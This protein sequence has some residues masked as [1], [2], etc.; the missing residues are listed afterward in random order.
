MVK[1]NESV[2]DQ[3]DV[4]ALS[5]LVCGADVVYKARRRAISAA[6]TECH[7]V[8]NR[9]FPRVVFWGFT[10]RDRSFSWWKKSLNHLFHFIEHLIVTV[11]ELGRFGPCPFDKVDAILIPYLV[12]RAQWQ[13]KFHFHNEVLLKRIFPNAQVV[14]GVTGARHFLRKYQAQWHAS[15][16]E[17]QAKE[18]SKPDDTIN[19]PMCGKEQTYLSLTSFSPPLGDGVA[20]NVAGSSL[21]GNGG[22]H[23]MM[24]KYALTSAR[25][26]PARLWHSMLFGDAHLFS[27]HSRLRV[28]YIDRQ[29]GPTL[30]RRLPT[31]WH[32]AIV[33]YLSQAKNV[34]F[35]HLKM[36]DYKFEKQMEMA[37]NID[38][39]V[40]AHGNGLSHQMFM[41]PH[42]FVLEIFGKFEFQYDY[43]FLSIC[44]GHKYYCLY[45]D[46]G[47]VD[48]SR[49]LV[50]RRTLPANLRR[51]NVTNSEEKAAEVAQVV[52]SIVEYA[53]Q[54]LIT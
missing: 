41:R 54:I 35:L 16:Q 29:S 50:R 34:D 3:K 46:D 14:M 31:K 23:S 6:I 48:V 52:A 30:F 44:M 27:N 36:E 38:V 1:S 13:G 15:L 39:L 20:C 9:Y 32:D 21:H 42:R 5:L 49:H 28:G 19:L 26:F 18:G 8:A 12:S 37:S 7:H 22:V 40:G 17:R 24:N 47:L 53:A 25:D 11:A 45:G 10:E 33:K 4:A 2:N 43:G 51:P